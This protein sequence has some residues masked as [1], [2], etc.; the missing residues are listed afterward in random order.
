MFIL[1]SLTTYPFAKFRG[2]RSYMLLLYL[3]AV[4]PFCEWVGGGF[5]EEES[6]VYKLVL[7]L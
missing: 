1:E 4:S 7:Y 5:T 6:R 3:T 2:G